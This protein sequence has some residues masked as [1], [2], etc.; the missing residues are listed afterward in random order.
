MVKDVVTGFKGITT[1]QCLYLNNCVQFSVKPNT[2]NKDGT[3]KE[4]EWLDE[5]RLT[6][7]KKRH[8]KIGTAATVKAPRTGGPNR[9]APKSWADAPQADEGSGGKDSDVPGC[10]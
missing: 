10:F 4:S 8:V 1:A 6:V 7:V 5:E 2:L 3:M 9:G